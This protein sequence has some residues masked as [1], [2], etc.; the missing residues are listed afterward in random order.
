MSSWII[1]RNVSR[2]KTVVQPKFL[3][4]SDVTNIPELYLKYITGYIY[5]QKMGEPCTLWDPSQILNNTLRS[6]PQVRYLKE[7]PI[8]T[9]E[10]S[11]ETFLSVVSKL[12]FKEIQKTAGDLMYYNPSF[13]NDVVAVIN[14]AGIKIIFDI[15]FHLVKDISGPNPGMFKMYADLLKAY[16][17]KMKKE[18]LSVYI[19]ADTYNVV[20][21]FQSYCDP[22]WKIVSLSRTPAKGQEDMFIQT[23]ADIQILTAIP[24]LILDYSRPEDRFI[25]LM[26]RYRGG[27]TYFK[28][29]KDREWKLF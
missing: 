24:A 25:Y 3:N 8:E 19:M 13:N 27:L 6:H 2:K 5:F 17:L 20:T 23:M 14:R 29:V 21:Q 28:E 15:G 18:N 1:A 9:N 16:Q 11:L 26:Q 7:D 12:S 22:S 10:V 4:A